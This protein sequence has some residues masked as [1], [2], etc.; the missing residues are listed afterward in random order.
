[1]HIAGKMKIQIL[2]WNYLS[3]TAAGRT[4][5]FKTKTQVPKKVLRKS[6]YCFL[7]LN[8]SSHHPS[9]PLSL[10]FT[11]ASLCRINCRYQNQLFRLFILI[12][13]NKSRFNF[14][15]YLPYNTQI[16]FL[17]TNFLCNLINL[18]QLCFLSNFQICLVHS[19]ASFFL[20]IIK[21]PTRLK[22]NIYILSHDEPD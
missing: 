2:H 8:D 3:I 6:N 11:F 1:M 18:Q 4:R 21:R 9:L 12:L 16:I 15:L 13:F 20:S 19:F 22:D 5:P 7:Y 17:N 10:D 14:A